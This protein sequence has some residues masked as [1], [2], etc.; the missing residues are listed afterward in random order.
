MHTPAFMLQSSPHL[1]SYPCLLM[2]SP[3][4]DL[5]S[6]PFPQTQILGS[7]GRLSVATNDPPM[8][9]NRIIP[10]EQT[11]YRRISLSEAPFFPAFVRC[12]FFT[13]CHLAC[14]YGERRSWHFLVQ[15]P[16]ID[17]Y[18]TAQVHGP[19]F[20]LFCFQLFCGYREIYL[21]RN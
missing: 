18:W 14:S 10:L 17:F 12:V 9:S 1:T 2:S 16:A 7:G 20:C 19:I 4:L 6:K 15:S 21:R 5:Q 8:M 3:F 11:V 13:R